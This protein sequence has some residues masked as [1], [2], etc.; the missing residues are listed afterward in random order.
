V[1]SSIAVLLLVL[2]APAYA[3][4]DP[5]IRRLEAEVGGGI[6]GGG[7]LGSADANLRANA[8]T[9][10]RYTLFTTDSRFAAAGSMH[11]RVGFALSS[12][13]A[14]E[15]GL[16]FSHPRIRTSVSG[17]VEGAA[18]LTVDE[19]IDQ[20]IVEASVLFRLDEI[21]LGR[22]TV[23]FVAGGAG[24]LRQL[25]EGLTVIDEGHLY[26]LGGGMKHWLL[27]RDRGFI[28]AAGLRA[29]GRLYIISGGVSFDDRPRP[30]A[31]AS[32]SFFLAF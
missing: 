20:Y 18:A 31:A 19:R 22:R 6:F 1:K 16:V 28:R 32:G 23:P 26:H 27:A 3:Q 25:H 9:L 14:V 21:R 10:Q 7:A 4:T 8:P 29:D 30:H 11:G 24:Y 2:A 13:L 12:R 15:G 17:D 5:P